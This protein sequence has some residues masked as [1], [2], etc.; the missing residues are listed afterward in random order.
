[1]LKVFCRSHTFANFIEYQ[2]LSPSRYLT[3]VEWKI[4]FGSM[5]MLAL[6]WASTDVTIKILI[7][8]NGA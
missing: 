1:M 6:Y 4:L 3:I 2:L 7:L 5:M 8:G